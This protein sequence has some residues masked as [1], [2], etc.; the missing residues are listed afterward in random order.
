MT[1]EGANKNVCPLLRLA[2]RPGNLSLHNAEQLPAKH[3]GDNCLKTLGKTSAFKT[4]TSEKAKFDCV[5][6]CQRVLFSITTPFEL[7][8]VTLRLLQR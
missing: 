4:K 5:L 3:Y 1:K 8:L 7:V 6:K 2:G